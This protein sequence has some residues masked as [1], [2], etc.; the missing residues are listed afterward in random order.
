MG[1]LR[2]WDAKAGRSAEASQ[3]SFPLANDA[4]RGEPQPNSFTVKPVTGEVLAAKGSA[5]TDR[6]RTWS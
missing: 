2:V 4:D 5:A 3:D 6:A 1:G